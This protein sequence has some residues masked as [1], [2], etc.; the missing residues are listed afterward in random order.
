MPQT[1]TENRS[2]K[3]RA[4]SFKPF[5]AGGLCLEVSPAGGKWW[6]WRYC[7]DGRQPTGASIEQG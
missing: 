5:D 2:A 6:R 3:L 1:D 4:T 7:F